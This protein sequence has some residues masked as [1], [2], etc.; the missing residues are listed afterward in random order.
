MNNNNSNNNNNNVIN[1]INNINNTNSIIIINNTGTL[2][3]CNMNT[4]VIDT[5][6]LISDLITNCT[7]RKCK[8]VR[9]DVSWYQYSGTG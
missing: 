2:Y 4:I 7:G 5:I 6:V 8:I 1:N 9:R 3:N